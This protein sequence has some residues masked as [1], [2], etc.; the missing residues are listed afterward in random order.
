MSLTLILSIFNDPVIIGQA[1][2]KKKRK[3]KEHRCNQLRNQIAWT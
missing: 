3:K 1:L 2:L